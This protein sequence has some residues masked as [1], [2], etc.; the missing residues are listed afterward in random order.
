M[1]E[2]EQLKALLREAA[3]SLDDANGR[4][5]WER[6]ARRL[7]EARN[8]LERWGTVEGQFPK[9]DVAA[10]ILREFGGDLRRAFPDWQPAPAA[11]IPE[12]PVLGYVQAGVMT[13][14]DVSEPIRTISVSPDLWRESPLWNQTNPVMLRNHEHKQER[15]EVVLLQIVGDSMEPTYPAG[16]II[17][18][19]SPKDPTMLQD[20]TPCIFR[21]NEGQTFKTLR[22]ATDGSEVAFI[23]EP[24]NPAH[25]RI[26]FHRSKDVEILF[27]VVGK[28]DLGIGQSR[29]TPKSLDRIPGVSRGMKGVKK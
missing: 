1:T 9:F 5:G 15:H 23:G 25:R 13:F 6:L 21:N 22:W 11:A 4:G 20:G 7:G 29:T 24:I 18:C 26:V 27:V 19:R 14:A 10:K 12:L 8:T 17:A 28:L 3:A 16:L 2:E